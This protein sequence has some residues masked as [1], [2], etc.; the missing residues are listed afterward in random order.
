MIHVKANGIYVGASMHELRK[1]RQRF[2]L[3]DLVQIHHIIPLQHRHHPF[4]QE[5]SY[6]RY[7]LIQFLYRTLPRF[8]HYCVF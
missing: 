3:N 2:D 8:R 6:S 7:V 1:T 5:I 4:L